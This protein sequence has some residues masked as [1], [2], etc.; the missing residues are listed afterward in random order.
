[1]SIELERRSLADDRGLADN[2]GKLK[3]VLE[4]SA[5][6]TIPKLELAHR[7]LALISA[8]GLAF[9]HKNF[10]SALSFANRILANGGQPKI[11]ENVGTQSPAIAF[12]IDTT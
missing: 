5:Y 12:P 4:L 8:M 7:Q 1:M 10:A 11:L 6:F 9:K 3:R 2:P